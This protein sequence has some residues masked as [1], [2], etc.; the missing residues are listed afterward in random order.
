MIDKEKIWFDVGPIPKG[1]KQASMQEALEAN[2]IFKYGEKKVDKKIIKKISQKIENENSDLIFNYKKKDDE[3]LS[4][5]K[6]SLKSN[7]PQSKRY[8]NIAK[9]IKELE[10]YNKLPKSKKF[11]EN[12]ENNEINQGK[13][14]EEEE[15]ENIK[16]IIEAIEE[17]ETEDE[18]KRIYLLL[19]KENININKFPNYIKDWYMTMGKNIKNEKINKEYYN[20]T[21][22]IYNN[23]VFKKEKEIINNL[24]IGRLKIYDLIDKNKKPTEGEFDKIKILISKFIG[25]LNSFQ[26]EFEFNVEKDIDKQTKKDIIINIIALNSI[27]SKIK[28]YMIL[29]KDNYRKKGESKNKNEINNDIK[30][31]HFLLCEDNKCEIISSANT[32]KEAKDLLIEKFKSKWENLVGKTVY[33]AIIHLSSDG[34]W[35]KEKDKL[36]PGPIYIE[37]SEYMIEKNNKLNFF[38]SGINSNVYFTEE[39]LKKNKNINLKDIK[40]IVL[41][42]KKRELNQ[43][44][45]SKNVFTSE[46][47][48]VKKGKN[49]NKINYDNIINDIEKFHFLLCE[50][51]KC[52]IISSANTKK[53]AKDLLIEKFKSKWENLVGKTVYLAII[54]KSEENWDKEKDKMVPGPIMMDISEYKILKNKDIK[55]YD[56]GINSNVY[57]T[58]EYLKKNK[59]I[60]LKD[61]K[62]MVLK[63]KKRELKKGLMSKNVL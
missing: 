32:K 28:E 30:K 13:Q 17:A 20:I 9:Q 55:F 25:L 47:L 3:I 43:G 60:N 14:K 34:E 31:F 49:E 61:V 40:E 56:A 2:K 59:N 1:Y 45:M 39:Y 51:N 29:Y 8:P 36:V 58:E 48:N 16:D 5:L 46:G 33:L 22:S 18:Q 63:Y 4:E 15:K 7:L 23:D 27:I 10:Y 11:I 12:I 38:S 62:E 57:F 41:K 50:D 52:E 21:K 54:E 53:E 24:T 6:K 44:L 19:L 42:Y 26:R 37:I 35:E